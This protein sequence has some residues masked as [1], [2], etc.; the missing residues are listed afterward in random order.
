MTIPDHVDV[1]G[2]LEVGGQMRFNITAVVGHAPLAAD[3][4]GTEGTLRSTLDQP[5]RCS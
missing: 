2:R 3:I 4:F 1:V 5:A